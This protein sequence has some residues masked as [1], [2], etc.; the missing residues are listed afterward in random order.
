MLSDWGCFRADTASSARLQRCIAQDVHHDLTLYA[1]DTRADGRSGV[2]AKSSH[3]QPWD[4]TPTWPA[5]LACNRT[6]KRPRME[7]RPAVATDE[8]R[9]PGGPDRSSAVPQ[10]APHL[11]TNNEIVKEMRQRLTKQEKLR[12]QE[13]SQMASLR[14]ELW[15]S[16]RHQAEAT[17]KLLDAKQTIERLTQ[18]MKDRV[19][20]AVLA[21][22]NADVRPCSTS[23]KA[24]LDFLH[25]SAGRQEYLSQ[26]RNQPST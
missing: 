13:Q 15:E 19:D 23:H 21:C 20:D 5:P 7:A 25:Y 16:R 1:G 8:E 6:A 4:D 18:E 22:I 17:M 14:D 3:W 26:L 12:A 9:L 11:R 2:S 24:M 10:A